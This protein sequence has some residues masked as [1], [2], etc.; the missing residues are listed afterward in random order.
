MQYIFYEAKYKIVLLQTK[1]FYSNFN[2]IITVT[3][4]A[5]VSV[6]W[7]IGSLSSKKILN[8]IHHICL[9]IGLGD[10]GEAWSRV[11]RVGNG[12]RPFRVIYLH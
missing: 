4:F 12:V 2:S 7:A 3:P 11:N 6:S 1:I 8:K 9:F 5:F 10:V